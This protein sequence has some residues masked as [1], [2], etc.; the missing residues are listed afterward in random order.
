MDRPVTT[1]GS[2]I[3]I[4]R[5]RA[6]DFPMTKAGYLRAYQLDNPLNFP[7]NLDLIQK[8]PLWLDG[9]LPETWEEFLA[10]MSVG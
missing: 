9:E 1:T 4:G 7:L 6:F 2:E 8:V 5:M 3:L 10:T